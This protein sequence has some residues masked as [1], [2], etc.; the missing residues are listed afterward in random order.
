MRQRRYVYDFGYFDSGAMYGTD[1][2]F[3]T[4]TGTFHE[5][6]HFAETQVE[7]YFGT[8]LGGHLGSIGR[9]LLGTAEAHLAGGRP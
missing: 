5:G 2:R 4:V 8:I 3:A 9:V 7:S 1:G 6:L